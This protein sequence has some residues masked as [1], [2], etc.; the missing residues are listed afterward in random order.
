V[1][2]M[3]AGAGLDWERSASYKNILS[4]PGVHITD[5]LPYLDFIKLL[6]HSAFAVT[7]S[8]VVQEESTAVGVPCLT[9]RESTERPVTVTHGTAHLVGTETGVIVRKAI[10]VLN[11]VVF[12]GGMPEK[13]DGLAAKRIVAVLL[14]QEERIRRMNSAV[15]QRGI[16]LNS[17][18]QM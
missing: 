6:K 3:Q 16:C 11:G 14:Q 8:G 4:L 13:W 18:S 1:F 9:V 7:D 12:H 15:K 17:S 5:P 2:P 10:E